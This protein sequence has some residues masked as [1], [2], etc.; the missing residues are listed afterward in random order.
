MPWQPSG[1]RKQEKLLE[2]LYGTK[3]RHQHILQTAARRVAVQLSSLSFSMV[4]SITDVTQ[5]ALSEAMP[6]NCPMYRSPAEE[7]RGR[8]GPPADIDAEE[9]LT[10]TTTTK[11]KIKRK[12]RFG[13]D[14]VLKPNLDPVTVG[15]RLLPTGGGGRRDDGDINNNNKRNPFLANHTPVP[16]GKGHGQRLLLKDTSGLI[17]SS[18]GLINLG[19]TSSKYQDFG[20][21]L[22]TRRAM[23]MIYH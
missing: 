14:L 11:R 13:F 19:V 10:T 21:T 12:H 5:Q 9:L 1:C 2:Q 17:G 6:T 15:Q 7:G 4:Q 3:Q 18:D 8:Q 23:T 16:F 20:W 22:P